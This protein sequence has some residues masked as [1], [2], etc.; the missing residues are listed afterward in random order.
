MLLL[1]NLK[2]HEDELYGLFKYVR[3]QNKYLLCNTDKSVHNGGF[4]SK[5]YFT[6]LFKKHT[7]LSPMEFRNLKAGKFKS[8]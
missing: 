8:R 2:G 1:P 4:N 7:G 6:T 3:I 5:S